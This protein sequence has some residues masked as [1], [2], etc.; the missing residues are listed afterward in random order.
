MMRHA[1]SHFGSFVAALAVG[2]A[3]AAAG[4]VS[5]LASAPT[6]PAK[7]VARQE[8]PGGGSGGAIYADGDSYN[9]GIAGT[10]IAATSRARAAR[11]SSWR[12]T[13]TA[14]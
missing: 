6:I 11:S 4:G 7:D 8:T 1:T 12:T 13:T 2:L 3:L 10:V 5:Y 9:V 14:R